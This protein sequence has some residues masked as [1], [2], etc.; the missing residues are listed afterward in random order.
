MKRRECIV[1]LTF[2]ATGILVV[3]PI[4]IGIFLLNRSRKLAYL[5]MSIPFVIL[6]IGIIW[7][8]YLMGH[9]FVKN[10]PLEGENIGG[11]TLYENLDDAFKEKYGD[12]EVQENE[13]Y[14]ESLRFESFTVG[15]NDHD[16]I[17]YIS[18]TDSTMKTKAGIQIGDPIEKV[19]ETYGE[20]YY[21]YNEMGLGTS[22]NYVDREN[23]LHLQFWYINDEVVSIHL[24]ES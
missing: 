12:Y 13:Y 1:V 6:A 17:I 10:T 23:R 14:K 24:M 7:S 8:M 15:T 2:I 4:L 20:N 11:I 9:N 3:L 21:T 18:A 5:F 16:Q 22:I 19:F